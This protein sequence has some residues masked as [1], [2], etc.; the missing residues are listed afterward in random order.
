M[1]SF[2]EDELSEWERQSVGSAPNEREERI[3]VSV[4]VRPLNGKETATNDFAD[5]ECINSTTVVFKNTMGD[6]TMYPN[7]YMYD[8]VFGPNS[9]TREVYHEAAKDVAL[10]VLNGIN[11]S[12][13]AYGQTSSGKTFTM[14]GITQH[15]IEDIFNYI[16]KQNEREFVLKFSALEI[17]N[18]A[19]RDLLCEDTTPLRLL[20]DPERGTVVERLTE[21]TLRDKSHLLE[22]IAVC[23]AQRQ[24][25]ETVLNE[26]SS[27]SHQ[28]LR[29][30]IES[31]SRQLVGAANS[32][33]LSAVVNFVDLAGS[34]RSSQSAGTRL[35]EGSH[36]NRSLL[37][38]GTVI[39]KLSK[40][41][42]G[43]VPFRDSKLT[44][45]LQHS[46]GGN[47]RTAII[48]TMSPAHSHV[49]QSR[50]TLLFATCAK[51]VGTNA[52]VNVVVSDKALVKQ[53]RKELARLEGELKNMSKAPPKG[54][55]S[56]LLREK[57]LQIEKMSK[58]IEELSYQ[59]DLAQT[60]IEELL[61]TGQEEASRKLD[62]SGRVLI[63]HQREVSWSDESSKRSTYQHQDTDLRK[64]KSLNYYREQKEFDVSN[65]NSDLVDDSEGEHPE[66]SLPGEN[67]RQA[68]HGLVEDK[69]KEVGCI[70]VKRVTMNK[71]T[72][73]QAM[74]NT[75][76]D[77]PEKEFDSV[78]SKKEETEPI[79]SPAEYNALV[80]RIRELQTTIDNLVN[81]SPADNSPFL[82]GSERSSARSLS[83]SRSRS[84]R[85]AIASSP[86]YE[87]SGQKL[88]NEFNGVE[89][90]SLG[91][92]TSFPKPCTWNSS[93][94]VNTP[95]NNPNS[96]T[97]I[98]QEFMTS[99]D[100]N[101]P[102][103]EQEGSE[104]E[105][106]KDNTSN[107]Q[108][109]NHQ[110]S[111]DQCQDSE[112]QQKLI[113]LWDSC[114][115][116]I[117]HRSYF[118]LLFTGSEPSDSMYMEV[119][120]RR[121]SF[122]ESKFSEGENITVDGQILAPSTSIK[123]LNQER[124]MLSRQ[125]LRKFTAKERQDLFRK[126]DIGLDSKRRRLQLARRLWTNPN[127]MDHVRE[128][129]E[130]VAKLC[131]FTN[132]GGMP[133]EM[134]VGPNFSSKSLSKRSYSWRQ[135]HLSSVG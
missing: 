117:V 80:I 95:T 81:Q 82:T 20:D 98:N 7:A 25:G 67:L 56:A 16:E 18:E 54:D 57:E 120:L 3:Q 1:G 108:N 48:C 78:P 40:G 102:Q 28:I 9:S 134:F 32:S 104:E 6:R 51:E 107:D 124:E 58:E 8:R 41:R 119:E 106:H 13:F 65:H 64:S 75:L 52:R 55:S 93:G 114:H 73:T 115:T 33:T 90:L 72:E 35:K 71:E 39:R 46:L 44:R 70:E 53:L 31:S 103:H 79:P 84:C 43:H 77:D 121:L 109:T 61:S 101:P 60:R 74:T 76:D 30:T 87:F 42:N 10:S 132:G 135:F 110:S 22:L 24:I 122:I 86:G 118:F 50:N 94:S 88:G 100:D 131:G 26:T 83:L 59:R 12:V 15:T 128:S 113:K 85:A 91:R 29:L 111:S 63:E 36:I 130:L 45:I 96:I 27:R 97:N 37:T 69:C 23:E 49:E 2:G 116:P 89:R 21:E 126:W 123:A 133:K 66:F 105:P 68:T 5:W 34:E 14:V 47:A 125:M 4:R 62:Q 38:L 19:V 11:S 129:A 99:K 92:P 127:D 112:R 17:Y